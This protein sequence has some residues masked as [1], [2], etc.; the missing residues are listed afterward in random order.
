M[1]SIFFLIEK[2]DPLTITQRIRIIKTY[3]KNGDS[4]T[5]LRGDYGEV[6]NIERPV[7]HRFARSVGNIAIVSESVAVDSRVSIPRRCQ[8]LGLSYGTL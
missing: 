4:A 8:E 3:Y 6:I 5:A 7:H 2:I 1:K